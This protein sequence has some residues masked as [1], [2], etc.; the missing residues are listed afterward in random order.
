MANN[1]TGSSADRMAHP[2]LEKL[3][4]MPAAAQNLFA[5]SVKI[6]CGKQTDTN[7]CCVAGARPGL[8]A[9]EVNIQNLNFVEAPVAKFV[10]PLINSGAVVAREP[11]IANFVGRPVEVIKLPPLAATMD[12]CCR[13]AEMVPPPSGDTTLTIALLTIASLFELAVSV[14]YTATPLRGDGISIDVAYVPSRLLAIRGQ[15]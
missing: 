8:Y 13:I 4:P 12:D 11:D 7:C 3:G 2:L 1:Q 10:L 6:V 15:G 14:V 5:Y 9:T